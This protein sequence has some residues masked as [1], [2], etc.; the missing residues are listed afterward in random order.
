MDDDPDAPV[1]LPLD[2][3]LDLH[4]FHPSDAKH[5]VRG[6][7]GRFM[8]PTA[9]SIPSFAIGVKQVY[10]DYNIMEYYCN[11]PLHQCNLEWLENRYGESF[12]WTNAE[13]H[14][15]TLFDNIGTDVQDPAMTVDQM[16][17]ARQDPNAHRRV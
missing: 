6:S 4:T 13:G 12:E 5:V 1:P 15:Y 17:R 3:V 9:L 2:G 16:C 7:W 10:H 8:D 14:T 11:L